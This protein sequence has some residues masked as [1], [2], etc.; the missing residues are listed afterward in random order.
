MERRC[1]GLPAGEDSRCVWL[2]DLAV[3]VVSRG[4]SRWCPAYVDSEQASLN[5][6]EVT[7]QAV[8]GP[9][10]RWPPGDLTKKENLEAEQV[11]RKET[12]WSSHVENPIP[13][14]QTTKV[15]VFLPKFEA[16]LKSALVGI[17]GVI[18]SDISKA[19]LCQ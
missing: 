8:Q 17:C 10:R 19:F 15:S 6:T 14:Q 1:G 5:T 18:E 2:R 7:Q 12:R 9:F 13:S 16:L 11:T 3:N 4:H